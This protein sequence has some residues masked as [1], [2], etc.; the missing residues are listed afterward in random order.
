MAR[1]TTGKYENQ[2]PYDARIAIGNGT[3]RSAPMAPF[4]TVGIAL[5]HAATK[6]ISMASVALR[7]VVTT[8]DAADQPAAVTKSLIQ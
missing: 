3:C 4:S 8:L 2:Y 5:Q 1:V 7:P 6:V